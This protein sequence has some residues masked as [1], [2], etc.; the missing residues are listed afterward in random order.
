MSICRNP[1][2]SRLGLSFLEFIGCLSALAGGAVL[3]S[4]YLGVDVR[5]T[6]IALL[7]RTQVVAP[8]AAPTPTAAA[9]TAPEPAAAGATPLPM[10]TAPVAN[11]T[12]ASAQPLAALAAIT[13]TPDERKV[14][15]RAYWDA[16]IECVK[17]EAEHRQTREPAVGG[18]E[19]H[20]YLSRR[21]EGHRTAAESIDQLSLRG[22]DAHIAAYAE[23][24]QAWHEEGA[25]LFSEAQDL[26]TD[27]PT[28]Q[29]SGPFAQG[30]QSAATQHQMEERL[31]E[32]KHR[33]VQS[34]LDHAAR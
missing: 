19:L 7:Q 32:E 12:D 30:W 24:I 31:L 11:P 29:L 18:A 3:G 2:S 9:P 27:A 26:L 25:S 21:S 8:P 13:L 6:T 34:Y 33:A 10:A 16:L 28:A 1:R 14:L 23:S 17:V 4:I 15:T 22:V 5:E 20:E